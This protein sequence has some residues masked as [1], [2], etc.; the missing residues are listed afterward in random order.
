M[1]SGCHYCLSI[2]TLPLLRPKQCPVLT[3]ADLL[4]ELDDRER[5]ALAGAITKAIHPARLA[6]LSLSDEAERERG[7]VQLLTRLSAAIERL[8]AARAMVQR[9]A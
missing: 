9:R 3:I 5:L 8:Q 2:F 4:A 6:A 1:A 7:V